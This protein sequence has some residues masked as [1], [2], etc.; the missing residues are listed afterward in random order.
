MAALA[1]TSNN[2]IPTEVRYSRSLSW[3]KAFF[4]SPKSTTTDKTRLVFLPLKTCNINN[5]IN[6]N[7]NLYERPKTPQNITNVDSSS[8]KRWRV[9][10]VCCLL[11]RLRR[12]GGRRRRRRRGWGRWGGGG[13][14]GGRWR[15]RRVGQRRGGPL[16]PE[17][18]GRGRYQ[19]LW[20]AH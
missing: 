20:G 7:I 19:Q 13:R 16:W 6:N 2:A 11:R 15:G 1:A 9:V 8:L 4:C 3:A 10:A 17:R 14:G 12:R 5:N 18:R